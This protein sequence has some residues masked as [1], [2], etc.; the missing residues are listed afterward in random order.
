M[1]TRLYPLT[2]FL[3][4]ATGIVASMLCLPHKAFAIDG[5]QECYLT[6]FAVRSIQDG[7]SP[8]DAD[9]T[10]GNDSAN[11]NLRVRSFDY[12]NYT[13]EFTTALSD[14]THLVDAADLT[15]TF[16]LPMDPKYAEFNM[17]AMNWMAN[18]SLTYMYTDGTS[19]STWNQSKTVS[20][21]VLTGIRHISNS[22]S[23][24]M[25]PGT[26]T[27]SAGIYVKASSEGDAIV[28]VFEANVS[29]NSASLALSATPST[30]T[31]TSIPRYNIQLNR[32]KV[33]GQ[34]LYFDKDDDLNAGFPRS[35]MTD[36]EAGVADPVTQK[37]RF[38]G[39][40]VKL[41]LYNSD[42]NK[43][44]RGLELPQG[45]ITCD[46]RIDYTTTPTTQ[47]ATP[48][49][50]FDVPVQDF[51]AYLWEYE[52]TSASNSKKKFGHLGR[53]MTHYG[54]WDTSI[55]NRAAPYNKYNTSSP[56]KSCWDGGGVSIVQ[57]ATDP[58]L[59]HV[60]WSNYTFDYENFHF[61][62]QNVI[63]AG[64]SPNY[65]VNIGVFA[66]SYLQFAV[67][68]TRQVTE[69][70]DLDF[71]V[72]FSNFHAQGKTGTSVSSEARTDDNNASI[73]VEQVVPGEWEKRVY[74][75][76]SPS[77]SP[78]SHY[79][80]GDAYASPGS[81]VTY[82]A[83][84]FYRDGEEPTTAMNQLVKF[85]DKI[86]EAKN[87]VNPNLFLR[88]S[89][90]YLGP[91]RF[92][93]AAKPDKTGWVD[94]NELCYTR[95]ENLIFFDTLAELENAGYTCV[96]LFCELRESLMFN[97]GEG[98][99][100]W[101]FTLHVKEDAPSGTVCEVVNDTRTWFADPPNA[102]WGSYPNATTGG[103]GLGDPTWDIGNETNGWNYALYDAASGTLPVYN[104]YSAYYIKS[105]YAN[106]TK[107]P[108]THVPSGIL[109]GESL[110]IVGAKAM[111]ELE[112]ADRDSGSTIPKSVYDLDHGQ[113]QVTYSVQPILSLDAVNQSVVDASEPT[114]VSVSVTLPSDLTYIM[115]S[116]SDDSI[117]ITD[118]GN[119]TSTLSW[120][121]PDCVPN[122][123]I[124]PITFAC[125][126][127]HAGTP[128]D[129]TNNQS[130]EITTTITSPVDERELTTANGNVV[131][132][133]ITVIKLEATSIAKQNNR[134]LMELGDSN[135]WTLRYG[136]SSNDDIS[137]VRFLDVLPYDGDTRGSDFTGYYVITKIT[138]DFS[139]APTA[140]AAQ[141]QTCTPKITARPQIR[142][143]DPE[144]VIGANPTFTE[145]RRL[146]WTTRT[147]DATTKTV[148]LDNIREEVPEDVC[149]LLF[150]FD[151]IPAHEYIAISIECS[152]A[153][154]SGTLYP[155]DAGYV[156]STGDI[157][158]NNFSQN[159]DSQAAVV[160]SNVVSAQVVSR[161]VSGLVFEDIEHD[162][163]RKAADNL[164]AGM[165]VTIYALEQSNSAQSHT[166]QLG[167]SSVVA[168]DAYDVLGNLVSP[169][170][171]TATGEYEF[172]FLPAGNYIV[173]FTPIGE[174]CVCT[175]H[176]GDLW[177]HDSDAC[178]TL[179]G[180]TV[181]NAYIEITLPD[182]EDMSS[183][184]YISRSNDLGI[185][186]YSLE[187]PISKRDALTGHEINGATF[188]L[189]DDDS[190]L[191]PQ[192][193]SVDG[194]TTAE[195]LP[196]SYTL[197]ETAAPTGYSIAGPVSI[198]IDRSAA[199]GQD[200][201]GIFTCPLYVNGHME[202][203]VEI[204]DDN[205]TTAFTVSKIWRD[206]SNRDGLRRPVTFQLK[207]FSSGQLVYVETKTMQLTEVQAV[208]VNIPAYADNSPITYEVAELPIA[209][210]ATTQGRVLGAWSTGY[211]TTFINSHTPEMID[212]HVTKI[213]DD[214]NDHDRIRPDSARISILL[215]GNVI[216][217][218]E[219]DDSSNWEND[220]I[221]LYRYHDGGQ[222]NA[223]QVQETDVPAY[224]AASVT[225]NVATG[226]TVTNT[227]ELFPPVEMPLTGLSGLSA[228]ILPI[229]AVWLLSFTLMFSDVASAFK[230]R[231]PK[232]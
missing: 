161:T 48:T 198:I 38:F 115:G 158:A 63:Q 75:S 98:L 26:G 41:E 35:Y 184:H 159:S 214:D 172:N 199:Y 144:N 45:D 57:D 44:L 29:G 49:S 149:A 127:G 191:V 196:G 69:T 65:T 170:T 42:V 194:H 133:A 1:R 206:D 164:V 156:Q 74:V 126:I 129:V 121:I 81:T 56:N 53:N 141:A 47:G 60:T 52:E 200:G 66:S 195:V 32:Q 83:K 188:S 72:V 3:I 140:Y 148:T 71:S 174:R 154:A 229:I 51:T 80:A 113:R 7:T 120:D 50:F 111:V 14:E 207:G 22:G 143:L 128:D 136:N 221:G 193:I 231:H 8:W 216:D 64:S 82:R 15:V 204:E 166:L 70:R 147:V 28:P 99:V 77:G 19:S 209:G 226:F 16:T 114:M 208:F 228:Y 112:V 173:V 21:Q 106:G 142:T 9:N 79:N 227:H 201:N 168:Y 122:A 183:P 160:R 165:S 152:Y 18:P 17:S 78:Q 134:E 145:W 178:V 27:L 219:V 124:A 34:L 180:I 132:T 33:D 101:A 30:V 94:D 67:T 192:T 46:M 190:I 177:T 211:A 157:Y 230:K 105:A 54:I 169:Q 84:L 92:Y 23:T 102:E 155:D 202:S 31:C 150:E 146:T 205:I 153:D 162:N 11:N 39:Y 58:A 110:L 43:G 20:A 137:Q 119:G 90:G 224:Y 217:T 131:S 88:N 5:A 197:T 62:A 2:V 232:T 223:Y 13:L 123:G 96:G 212:V 86:L 189:T 118:N 186:D 24:N 203:T 215:E 59:Y 139:A 37:G 73:Y 103:Y 68:F 108:G 220:F 167:R 187:M 210:Y 181:E 116:S 91:Y 222:E 25:I 40:G 107:Q 36:P 135:T 138:Y 151:T 213:W 61:P 225:G 100:D 97:T 76:E 10:R 163:V 125:L 182:V 87:D 12:I 117:A 104:G 85:D 95:E 130:I 218:V 175:R 93:Y 89:S 179:N 171:T 4:V 176:V 185:Y 6:S 55:A 109:S